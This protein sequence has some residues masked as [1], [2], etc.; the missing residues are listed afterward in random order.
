[1]SFDIIFVSLC[2][3]PYRTHSTINSVQCITCY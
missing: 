3:S 2:F 1:L